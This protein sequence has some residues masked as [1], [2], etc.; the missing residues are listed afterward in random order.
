ML[1]K[2][3][4]RLTS[5]V[6]AWAPPPSAAASMA[7]PRFRAISRIRPLSSSTVE[8]I[9]SSRSCSSMPSMGPMAARLSSSVMSPAT[10]INSAKAGERS[11]AP[12][13]TSIRSV[14]MP[15]TSERAPLLKPSRPRDSSQPRK[16]TAWAPAISLV[17]AGRPA[18]ARPSSSGVTCQPSSSFISRY[19]ML[20]TRRRR[21]AAGV[22]SSSPA[23]ELPSRSIVISGRPMSSM[24]KA[25]DPAS[26]TPIARVGSP[27]TLALRLMS[28]WSVSASMPEAFSRAMS[29]SSRPSM[30]IWAW[31]STAP[32]SKSNTLDRMAN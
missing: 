30:A 11:Q 14:A 25:P 26:S 13:S 9:V 22:S 16:S 20:S 5:V 15:S 12:M 10:V 8:S 27:V 6:S 28:K 23:L 4:V 7:S 21:T 32:A 2:A 17:S 19:K 29:A 31:A 24:P 18:S 1:S 3:S